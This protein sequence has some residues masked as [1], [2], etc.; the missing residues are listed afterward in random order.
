MIMIDYQRLLKIPMMI[1]ILRDK[2][3]IYEML[4]KFKDD[5]DNNIDNLDKKL[6]E[7]ENNFNTRLNKI[8]S[9]V[10]KLKQTKII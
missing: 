3:K 6:I 7:K 8:K 2:N 5:M 10:E 1:P 4:N 9:N